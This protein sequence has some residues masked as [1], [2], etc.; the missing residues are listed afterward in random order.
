MNEEL[1]E[2]KNFDDVYKVIRKL[3]D[4]RWIPLNEKLPEEW[5]SILV[6]TTNG[7]Y[8]VAIIRT[9]FKDIHKD[10][11]AWMPLPEPPKGE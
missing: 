10:I 7:W 3:T 1:N 6:T 4:E 8:G 5:Q 9:F 2:C 11:I